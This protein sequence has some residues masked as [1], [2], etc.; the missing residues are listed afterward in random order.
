M[1]KKM[2]RLVCVMVMM[3]GFGV[4]FS[5]VVSYGFSDVSENYW[6]KEEIHYLSE[7]FII[8]GMNDGTF[9]ANKPLERIHV[10]L[11]LDRAL[12]LSQEYWGEEL[13]PLGL[14]DFTTESS[15]FDEVGAVLANGIFDD[16]IMMDI[17]N[18]M[19]Q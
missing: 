17:L 4:V 2:K 5:P 3:V 9:G 16:I 8:K 19:N 13:P 12:N 11:M 14:K 15:H 10:A 18:R 7:R 1:K 6:A